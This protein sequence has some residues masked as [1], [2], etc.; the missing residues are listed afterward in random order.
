MFFLYTKGGPQGETHKRGA[1]GGGTRKVKKGLKRRRERKWKLIFFLKLFLFLKLFSP[2]PNPYF[3]NFPYFI[4][5]CPFYPF[6]RFYPFYPFSFH[7]THSIF[8]HF[9]LFSP[10]PQ[11]SSPQGTRRYPSGGVPAT[12]AQKPRGRPGIGPGHR[13]LPYEGVRPWSGAF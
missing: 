8:H 4:R 10:A 5:F 1:A 13:P 6:C 11:K 12:R 7:F 2:P 3:I 9:L